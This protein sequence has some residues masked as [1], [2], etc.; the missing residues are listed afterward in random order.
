M[1]RLRAE[2]RNLA[3]G[4]PRVTVR[5]YY[6]R[7]PSMAGLGRAK[8]AKASGSGPRRVVRPGAGS[9][10]PRR[11]VAAGG[12]LRGVARLADLAHTAQACLR[13]QVRARRALTSGA[14]C[15]RLFAGMHSSGANCV[16]LFARGVDG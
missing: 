9:T 14:N 4:T 12:A 8:E 13:H 6:D 16:N 10:V 3:S 1:R 7:L 5:R 2:A 11:K 15:V